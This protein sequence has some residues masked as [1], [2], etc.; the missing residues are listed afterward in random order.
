MANRRGWAEAVLLAHGREQNEP[1]API[2][3]LRNESKSSSAPDQDIWRVVRELQ[4]SIERLKAQPEAGKKVSWASDSI[5]R[6]TRGTLK[7]H[8]CRKNGHMA[9][10]CFNNPQSEKYRGTALGNSEQHSDT[11]YPLLFLFSR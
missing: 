8:F 1:Q 10:N 4:S 2:A 3:F 5:K 7:C 6:S 9:R 11:R